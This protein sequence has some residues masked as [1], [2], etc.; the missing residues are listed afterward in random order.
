MPESDLQLYAH[1]AAENMLPRRRQD[2]MLANLTYWVAGSMGGYQGKPTDF[3]VGLDKTET[4]PQNDE[5]MES[6]LQWDGKW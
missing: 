4:E 1:Y 6:G 3:L 2:Y 5:A